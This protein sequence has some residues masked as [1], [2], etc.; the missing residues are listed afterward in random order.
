MFK[1]Q[2]RNRSVKVD[3]LVQVNTSGE[4]N[5]NGVAPG[6][7]TVALA[8]HV[9]EKCPNMVFKGLMTIGALGNSIPREA[10]EPGANPDF[11]SLIQC[12]KY[13]SRGF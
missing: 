1:N 9:T 12:R 2:A 8:K 3:V 4:E 11:L 6:S 10:S 5:K 7:E 13:V